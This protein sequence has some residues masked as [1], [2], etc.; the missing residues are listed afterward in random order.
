[1]R[2]RHAGE[3]SPQMGRAASQ[4]QAIEKW[5]WLALGRRAI[6]WPPDW[7]APAWR[8]GRPNETD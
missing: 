1:M 4:A 7:A 6:H 3:A 8:S 5:S 2:R